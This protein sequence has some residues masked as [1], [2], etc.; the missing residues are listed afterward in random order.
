MLSFTGFEKQRGTTAAGVGYT[1]DTRAPGHRVVRVYDGTTPGGEV[2]VA[3]FCR[4]EGYGGVHSSMARWVKEG[5]LPEAL[6]TWWSVSVQATD[7]KGDCRAR[8]DPTETAGGHSRVIDF[9]WLLEATPENM[10][11]IS[12]EIVRRAGLVAGGSR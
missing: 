3:E 4:C 1:D 6:P 10:E 2:V 8:Y 7:S 12:D 5:C 9:A 11:R